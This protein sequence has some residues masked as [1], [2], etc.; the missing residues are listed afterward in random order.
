MSVAALEKT[1][2][3]HIKHVFLVVKIICSR[4][5]IETFSRSTLILEKT[6]K[7]PTKKT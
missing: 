3:V 2:K 1:T 5:L 6:P 4:N 7:N